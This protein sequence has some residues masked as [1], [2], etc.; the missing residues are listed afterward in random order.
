MLGLLLGR[1]VFEQHRAQHPD[2]EALQRRPAIEQPHLFIEDA[3]FRRRKAAAA[4]FP[5]PRRHGPPLGGHALEPDSGIRV[6]EAG[7]PTAPDDLVLGHWRAH[8]GW[9]I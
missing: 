2:A 7:A 4:V 1:A 5:G 9:A 3:C 8:A 6:L